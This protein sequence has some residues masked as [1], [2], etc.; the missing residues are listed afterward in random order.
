MAYTEF[1]DVEHLKT[2]MESIAGRI[3]RCEDP[4]EMEYLEAVRSIY[5]SD[6]PSADMAERLSELRQQF[7]DVKRYAGD[8]RM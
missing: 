7:R 6:L 5:E 2:P 4:A 8:S 3:S 1:N